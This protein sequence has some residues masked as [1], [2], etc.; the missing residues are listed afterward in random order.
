LLSAAYGEQVNFFTMRTGHR[1]RQ[2]IVEYFDNVGGLSSA[3]G[4]AMGLNIPC[5]TTTD[6][7]NALQRGDRVAWGAAASLCE[8]GCGKAAWP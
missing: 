4:S 5:K 3:R 8:V 1:Y 7:L 2:T 6:A